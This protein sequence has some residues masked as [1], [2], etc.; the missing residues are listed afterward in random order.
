MIKRTIIIDPI[1]ILIPIQD[2]YIQKQGIFQVLSEQKKEKEEEKIELCPENV[3]L[4]NISYAY[5]I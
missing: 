3:D 1:H 2:N 5:S 4:L